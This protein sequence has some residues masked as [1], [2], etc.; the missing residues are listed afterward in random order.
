MRVDIDCAASPF[1]SRVR[2]LSS[3][4]QSDGCNL[5]HSECCSKSKNGKSITFSDFFIE[6]FETVLCPG[7]IDT[8]ISSEDKMVTSAT[9]FG[10]L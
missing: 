5:Q 6:L 3:L 4:P 10:M 8:Q 7:A 1:S 9:A 2:M